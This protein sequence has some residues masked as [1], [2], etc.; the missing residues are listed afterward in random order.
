MT[1][2]FVD[3]MDLIGTSD[4][5]TKYTGLLTSGGSILA[6]GRFGGKYFQASG[7]SNVPNS[8]VNAGQIGINLLATKTTVV[9]GFGLVVGLINGSGNPVVLVLIDSSGADQLSI[10]VNPSTLQLVVYRGFGITELCRSAGPIPFNQWVYVELSATIDPAAGAI[11]LRINSSVAA[12][13]SGNTRQTANSNVQSVSFG[14]VHGFGIANA[15]GASGSYSAG[16][17]DIYICD[18]LGAVNN[19]FLGEVRIVGLLPSG[20]G[21]NTNF[22]IGGTTPAATNFQSVNENP[23]NGDVSYVSS[24]I[25]G[26]TDTYNY[27]DL[28]ASANLVLAVAAGPDARR[29]DSGARSISTRVRTGGS[30]ADSPTSVVLVSSYQIREMIMEV[31]PVTG[32]AWTVANVNSS[33]FGPKI[34]L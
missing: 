24:T 19:T 31:N 21:T 23:P 14:S 7:S 15:V 13:F 4:L 9:V 2:L 12:T 22:A 20:A 10:W 26:T 29:D 33:E 16:F 32:L 6:P 17:D 30:E 1:L 28:P 34:S 5:I 3:G 8:F 25:V 27:Q 18:S 11:T